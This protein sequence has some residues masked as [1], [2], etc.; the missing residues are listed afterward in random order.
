M[1]GHFQE[2]EDE[3]LETLYEF[4]EM[5]AERRVRTGELAERLG[6]SAPAASEMVQRLAQRGL[7]DYEAYRGVR[8]TESGLLHGRRMKRRHRLAEVLLERLPFDGDAHATACRLEHAIDDD[9]EVALTLWL[10]D[11]QH[12][13]SGRS[14]PEAEGTVAER[15][16]RAT[17]PSFLA[18]S[19]LLVGEEAEVAGVLSVDLEALPGLLEGAVLSRDEE[20]WRLDG[21]RVGLS[22][23][24]ADAIVVSRTKNAGA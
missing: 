2:F 4:F 6:V 10:G 22:E 7:V 12:D 24:L 14:I 13:P 11:P 23:A 15:L 17:G 21:E 16:S 19:R 3:Y 9:L 20:G 1:V 18:A 8:L 5:D